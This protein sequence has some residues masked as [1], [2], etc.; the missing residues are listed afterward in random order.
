MVHLTFFSK[1][2]FLVRY[3]ASFK[4]VFRHQQKTNWCIVT[5]KVKWLLFDTSRT[6]PQWLYQQYV[7]MIQAYGVENAVGSLH[8]SLNLF[9]AK[10]CFGK[11]PGPICH[12]TTLFIRERETKVPCFLGEMTKLHV[13]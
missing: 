8:F 3:F 2:I 1:L 9:K 4:F 10:H 7:A 12:L 5:S 11:W 6:I 13:D